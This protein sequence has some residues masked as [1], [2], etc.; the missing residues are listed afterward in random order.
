M[1]IVTAA[2]VLS[3]PTTHRVVAAPGSKWHYVQV[4][5]YVARTTAAG[6][7]VWQAAELLGRRCR[8]AAVA[9]SSAGLGGAPA[10]GGLHMREVHS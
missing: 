4:R 1:P 9:W 5:R 2:P 7:T 3:S 10:L 6:R 8:S